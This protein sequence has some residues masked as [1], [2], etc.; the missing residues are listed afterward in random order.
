MN[1]NHTISL[2]ELKWFHSHAKGL[3]INRLIESGTYV[4]TSAIRLSRLFKCKVVTYEKRKRRYLKACKNCKKHPEI[5]CVNGE[6]PFKTNDYD[7]NTVVLIDGPKREKA[8]Y[9]AFK[10][11]RKVAFVGIHDMMEYKEE[12]DRKFDNVDCFDL[13]YGFV[14]VRYNA[15]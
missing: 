15:R 3:K 11:Y 4:G 6:L 2:K 7:E 13:T 14:I 8:I 12:V 10:L 1:E 5:K 9:L